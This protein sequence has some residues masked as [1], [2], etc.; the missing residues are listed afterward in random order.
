MN[1]DG[2]ILAIDNGTQ[3]VRAL[4]F[5]S[6]GNPV[7]SAKLELEAYF[8]TSPGWAEQE[9][10]YF[11]QKLG[12]VCQ[13]LWQQEAADPDQIVA[14]ALT[15]QR[16]TV[17]NLDKNGD[18]LRPAILWLDQRRADITEPIPQP[19]RGLFAVAGQSSK[20]DY[21]RSK[22][23]ANW[24]AQHQPEIYKA[25]AKVLLL[26]GFLSYRLT[27]DYVDS[28][29]AIVG[30]LP[31]DFRKQRWAGSSHWAW[32]C[33]GI[34]SGQLPK[35]VKPGETLGLISAAA[36]DVTG[37]PAGLPLIA[38]ASDKA[39]E[40]LGSGGLKAEVGCLSFGTTATINTNSFR[41]VEPVRFIP[42]YAA[43]VPDA[44]NTEVMIYRG[45]WMVSWFKQQFGLREAQRA[46]ELGMT[47]EALFDDLVRE[48]P[49]GSMGLML[50]PY[51]SP[52]LNDRDMKGAVIGFGDLHTRSHIY[53]AI[54]EGL[55]YAL[56]EG[57]EQ[58][59]RR[60]G[61]RINRLSVSGGGSQSD[62]AMQ[63]TADI[64]GLPVERP[65]TH[66][67]SGLGAAID[68][69]VGIGLY[70]DFDSAVKAM[71]RT[72]QV[73]E[74]NPESHKLYQKLYTRVYRQMYRRLKPLYQEIR[75]ITGYP[76]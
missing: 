27:G 39:C 30:Y 73:F 18:P 46:K 20:I 41:Y 3:S 43:A 9:P 8:S 65:H 4:L 10:E 40:V 67:T 12:E 33:S 76:E 29:G 60:S 14:V 38:A 64:F 51:W 42:P 5:D 37:I 16:G 15:T 68:A 1:D 63:I 50:Q 17:I 53:R 62:A 55:I 34:K 44:Y 11:W 61:R 6:K 58:I 25:T 74:P 35:L 49:A 56:R 72:G 36:S 57:K 19:W 69:A 7:A 28:V 71:T 70:K 24:I 22:A 75:D 54:L 66:E 13:L 26:S 21:F 48:V 23:Q 59:E 47:P 52:G 32:S 2:L 45:F 31:F